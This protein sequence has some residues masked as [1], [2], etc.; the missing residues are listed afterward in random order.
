MNVNARKGLQDGPT[1]E[2]QTQKQRVTARIV[3]EDDGTTRTEY[4][5]G[6]RVYGS[7]E[8]LRAAPQ[9]THAQP[10]RT[11]THVVKTGADDD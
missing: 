5:V 7:L 11:E 8:A 2:V 1:A 4:R 9:S 3:Q 6:G 10:S